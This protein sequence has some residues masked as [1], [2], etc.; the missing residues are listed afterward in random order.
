MRDVFVSAKVDQFT[1]DEAYALITHFKEY[2]EHSDAILRELIETHLER[3]D[4]RCPGGH[5][6]Q[7]GTAARRRL[8]RQSHRAAVAI[9]AAHQQHMAMA[10]LVTRGA[11]R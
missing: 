6:H 9:V 8:R 5:R 11:S 3:G 4:V 10:A 1:A 7:A 2:P